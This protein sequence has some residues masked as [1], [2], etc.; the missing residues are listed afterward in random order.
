MQ[1]NLTMLTGLTIESGAYHLSHVHLSDRRLIAGALAGRG[2]AKW[3]SIRC[4]ERWPWFRICCRQHSRAR[5]KVWSR[6]PFRR[7]NRPIRATA[8]ASARART[9]RA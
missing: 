3:E 2:R 8:L 1:S 6:G 4:A 7:H 5:S 9:H